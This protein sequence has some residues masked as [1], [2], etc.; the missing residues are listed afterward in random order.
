MT[1]DYIFTA[2][3]HA[4]AVRLGPLSFF[5]HLSFLKVT[6]PPIYLLSCSFQNNDFKIHLLFLQFQ[7]LFLSSLSAIALPQCASN[8]ISIYS[9]TQ[10]LLCRGIM[11]KAFVNFPVQVMHIQAWACTSIFLLQIPWCMLSF[12]RNHQLVKVIVSFYRAFCFLFNSYC[13][14]YLQS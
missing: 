13:S 2:K 12:L 1:H 8:I 4:V 3:I 5:S 9:Q 11:N 10:Y 7:C 14:V 6:Q